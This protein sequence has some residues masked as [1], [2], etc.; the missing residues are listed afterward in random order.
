MQEVF[1][2]VQRL[3]VVA[4][5]TL[6]A[7]CGPSPDSALK[8]AYSPKAYKDVTSSPEYNFSTFSGTVWKTKTKV[9]LANVK[10][11]TGAYERTLLAPIHFDT[12]DPK[13][14]SGPE[15]H[16]DKVMPAGTQLQIGRLMEDQG[17]WGGVQV[18]AV[19]QDQKG[20][21]IVYL[22]PWL[23]SGN[24][25]SGGPT[26]YTNWGVNSDVLEAQ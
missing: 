8:Q 19:L 13:Y 20:E 5:V 10:R 7:G 23:L 17:A 2:S 16:V 14:T 24:K 11:Y 15:K 3:I 26:S 6:T 1:S 9:A 18:E 25:W 12:A 21:S 4:C 22:D